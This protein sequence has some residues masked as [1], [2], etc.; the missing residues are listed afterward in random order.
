MF[1]RKVGELAKR[2]GLVGTE[3]TAM[4]AAA[5]MASQDVDCLAAVN[6]R[7]VVGFVLERDL[8]RHLDVDLEPGTPVTEIL[9]RS[10]GTVPG[11]MLVDEAVKHMLEQQRRHLVVQGPDGTVLG[12]VTDKELVD[13]LAVDFMV[14]NVTCQ[15]LVRS[16]TVMASP[17]DP[18]RLALARM[19]ERD[20]G[21]LVVVEGG[22][23]VGIFTERDATSKILGHPER[24]T[25][26]LG[27]YMSS[28]VIS[29]PASAMVYKVI[30]FMRQK[31]VRRVAVTQ[32]QDGSLAGILTQRH[33]LAYARR[34]G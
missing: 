20:T 12:M 5:A 3:A 8:C 17:D 29:V 34:L 30:L 16:D 28:P 18:V 15:D 26:P 13:A 1:K 4:A 22:K 25:E 23:P 31:G 7:K 14:E 10:V 27:R 21:S 9:S 11:S 19:R 24:L 32:G 2:P 6:G 33:I